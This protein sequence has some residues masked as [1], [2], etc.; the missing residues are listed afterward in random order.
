MRALLG[1]GLGV[2]IDF[3][4]IGL[5]A[6]FVWVMTLVNVSK[7]DVLIGALGMDFLFLLA[8][9]IAARMWG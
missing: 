4:L 8:F 1:I 6:L 3:L 7:V 2:T 5:I 9:L